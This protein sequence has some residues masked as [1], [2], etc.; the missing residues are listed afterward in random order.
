MDKVIKKKGGM[1][2]VTSH[3]SGHQKTPLLVTYYL[4]NFDDVYSVKQFLSYS[5]NLLFMQF[6]S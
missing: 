2:L 6:N 1:E 4:N 5:K 3:S